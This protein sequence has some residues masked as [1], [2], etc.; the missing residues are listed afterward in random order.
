MAVTAVIGAQWGDEG[1]GKIVDMLAGNAEVVARWGGGPNAGHTVVVDEQKYVLHHIPSGIL[2]LAAT[3][4]L[5]AGVVIDPEIFL[6]EVD[7]LEERG[8]STKKRLFIDGRAHLI[9]PYHR[10]LDEC[11][12]KQMAIGTTGRGIGPAYTDKYARNGI[13]AI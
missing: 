4:Y 12:E 3:C 9:L 11:Y 2:N 10:R 13:R 7:G 5:G 8:I 6:K 1:K